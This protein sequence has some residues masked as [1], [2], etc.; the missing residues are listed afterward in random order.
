[1]K[2][3]ALVDTDALVGLVEQRK[4][5]ASWIHAHPGPGSYGAEPPP[6]PSL[7]ALP[8]E[9]RQANEALQWY[10]R[11]ILDTAR[12]ADRSAST[13]RGIPASP[14]HSTGPVRII[15]DEHDFGKLQAGDV[16]VCPSTSP[17]WSVLFPSIAGLVTD[18]GGALSHP[19]IIAREY[20]VPAPLATGDATHR[21]HDGQMVVVDGRAGLVAPR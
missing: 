4:A 8:P 18:A 6:P 13:I 12:Q 14:G 1:M 16:L 2:R 19:A 10:T 9:A 17:V 20:G 15:L 21:L 5:E 11:Q 7:D 3:R